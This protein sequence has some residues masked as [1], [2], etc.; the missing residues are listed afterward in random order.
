MVIVDLRPT[1]GWKVAVLTRFE[2]R[3][4]RAVVP[5]I[6][7]AEVDLDMDG[8]TAWLPAWWDALGVTTGAPNENAW[9]LGPG[10]TADEELWA[11]LGDELPGTRP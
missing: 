6:G 4:H 2:G 3:D 9:P 7:W 1:L 10:E 5:M 8:A 11:G